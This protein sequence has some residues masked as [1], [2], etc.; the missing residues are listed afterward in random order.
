[1]IDVIV[2]VI[3]NELLDENTIYLIN[4]SHSFVVRGSLGDSGTT[5][6]EIVADTYGGTGRIGG[7]CFSSKDPTKVDRSAS[8]YCRYIA[9]NIVAHDLAHKCEIQVAYAI[10]KS[11]TISVMV[12]IFG[13]AALCNE[14]IS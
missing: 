13:T 8:Y 10:G 2:P 3:P 7:G 9:N 4:P 6:R 11:K 5:G 1:M 14:E 12:D